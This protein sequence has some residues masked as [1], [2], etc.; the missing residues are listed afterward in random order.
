MAASIRVQIMNALMAAL[1]GPGAPCKFW[2]MRMEEFQSNELPAGNLILEEENRQI[3]AGEDDCT[4]T[5]SLDCI[6]STT[7]DPVDEA[8]DALLVWAEQSIMADQTLGGL[9]TYIDPKPV[10]WFMANKGAKQC[11]AAI[12]F[13]VKFRTALTD[14]TA[15]LS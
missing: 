5:V 6:V 8:L 3:D 11:V 15:N 1:N 10:K 7:V 12:G 4:L 13:D 9:A 2:R 14:S